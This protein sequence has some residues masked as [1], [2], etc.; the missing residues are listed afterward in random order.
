MLRLII[1]SL[2][3]LA[4]IVA[5]VITLL[6]WQSRPA[7]PDAFYDQAVAG[8]A[9]GTL[10]RQEIF[11]RNVPL[12]T[13]AWRILYA[14]TR[15][16]N[17][18]AVASAIVVVPN[19]ATAPLPVIAWAHGT[20]GVAR[21]CA[22]SLFAN[23]FPYIPAFPDMF[24]QGWAYVG[25]DYVG[26][27]TQGGHAYL[28]GSDAA[29][30]VLDSLRAVRQLKD[31]Q[32]DARSLVWGHSQG[33]HSALWTGMQAATYAPD[34]QILGIAAL[35]PASDLMGLMQE[36]RKLPFGKIISAFVIDAYARTY[37]DLK[38]TD[39]AT[40]WSRFLAADMASRCVGGWET[41]FSAVVAKLAP[42][43]GLVRSDALQGTLAERLRQNT[44]TATIPAPLFIAQGEAD[45]LV[46]PSVQLNYVRA[47]CAAGQALDYRS[48]AKRDHLSL[49]APD[50]ALTADLLA[51][52]I[53][54]FNGKPASTNCP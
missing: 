18:P 12:G 14:T 4:L 44:P 28:V 10:L 50:S 36:G 37:P 8:L 29:R 40:G 41:L 51:W 31:V 52:S 26:Q 30:N 24:K 54:R 33:G 11:S 53:D 39:L 23:P 32:W 34:L 35:A 49:V 5:V 38:A 7:K 25:T 17:T 48:Y 3:A 42:E 20:T 47:R 1:K 43:E 6:W 2:L 19:N 46:F 22:P 21:G 16:D 9:P 13:K 27:G 45:D 15:Y